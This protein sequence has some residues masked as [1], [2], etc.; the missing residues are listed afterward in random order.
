MSTIQPPF[1]ALFPGQGSQSVGMGK[2]FYDQFELARELFEVANSTLGFSLSKLCFEGPGPD[3][4]RTEIGQPAIL[5]V[6]TIAFEL[7]QQQNPGVVPALGA[8]H[9]LG[10]YSALVSAGA[11][12]FADAVMLV[13][14][15]GKYMQ[16]A[17]PVG[18]GKM[19]AVIGAEVSDIQTALGN[20]E[21]VIE[22]AN[23][24]SPGQVV[25]SGAAGAIDKFQE[26]FTAKKL[27][28]LD[29]S[30]PFHCSLMQ[31]AADKLAKDLDQL[32]I[33]APKF[34]IVSNVSASALSEPEQIRQ[35]LKDQV[36]G[37]VRW[38]E[39]MQFAT[40]QKG[41]VSAVEFGHGNV[42]TGLLKRINKDVS[43]T[44]VATPEHLSQ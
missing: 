32:T 21:G 40:E 29:V 24:N 26:S 41:M 14:K 15:R 17:V 20:I 37:S 42:L 2:E 8:G 35:A 13:H 33:N 18:A 34:P 25:I 22:I 10:E 11:I 7:W 27:V 44:N 19:L 43:R 23:D 12:E 9:S 5:T 28:P 31:P 39:S 38:V 16:E 3:L 4:T 1:I 36:C 30:A 6:S